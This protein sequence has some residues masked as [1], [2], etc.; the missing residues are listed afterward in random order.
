MISRSRDGLKHRGREH[1]DRGERED[2]GAGW[3]WEAPFPVRGLRIQLSER[4]V[5]RVVAG[6]LVAA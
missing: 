5:V 2:R 1:R 6:P 3:R 4:D